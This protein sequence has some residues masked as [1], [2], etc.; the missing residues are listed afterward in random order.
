[1]VGEAMARSP[2]HNAIARGVRRLWGG[3]ERQRIAL[4][5]T[6]SRRAVAQLVGRVRRATDR[7]PRSA[8][9]RFTGRRLRSTPERPGRE[10]RAG[11]LLAAVDRGVTSTGARPAI[12]APVQATPARPPTLSDLRRRNRWVIGISRPSKELRLYHRL[13][14]RRTY[15]IAVGSI[16][17]QTPAGRYH[18]ETKAVDPVWT[19]PPSPWTGS[20]AGRHIPPGPD[21]PLK[22]RWLGIADGAGIHGTADLASLGTAASHGCIRM[23]VPDV[24][25][26]YRRV[27]VGALIF[28][29]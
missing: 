3:I 19:P 1:M 23:S 4:R 21:N 7:P 26:L 13:R 29:V 9:L 8:R 25:D 5:V 17:Y 12:A 28:I 16:G 24:I 15:R 10:L 14:L 22:A 27:P 6:Y 2:G 18:V 11:A 20:L